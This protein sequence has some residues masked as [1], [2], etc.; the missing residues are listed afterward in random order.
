MNGRVSRIVELQGG[1]HA[2]RQAAQAVQLRLRDDLARM[3][4]AKTPGRD[5]FI[6]VPG[7]CRR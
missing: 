4:G 2:V 6:A 1:P 7:G 3:P 5:C